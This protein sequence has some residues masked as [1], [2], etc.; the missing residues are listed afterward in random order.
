[1]KTSAPKEAVI[2]AT[3]ITIAFAGITSE[4]N[5]KS[6]A[7]KVTATTYP[8]TSGAFARSEALLS[9]SCAVGPPK[10]AGAPAGS[11]TARI[12]S[13]VA[14]ACEDCGASLSVTSTYALP[15]PA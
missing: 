14:C 2:E 13:S 7:T 8:I 4:P 15:P 1:M 3:F 6:S 5:C 10:S 11:A 9:T 12:R